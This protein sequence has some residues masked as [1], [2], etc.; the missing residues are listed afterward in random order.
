[1][2]ELEACLVGTWIHS[3]EED[4]PEG[5]V[6]RRPSY[7][8]P[9]ARGRRGFEL[10]EG[11]EAMLAGIA[12]TNGSQRIT[13]RWTREGRQ[14]RIEPGDGRMVPMTFEVVSCDEEILRVKR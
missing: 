14:I 6:Y 7:S 5:Q 1:M 8:F 11:G 12:P 2:A 4:T 3:H 9:P 13:A 10:R